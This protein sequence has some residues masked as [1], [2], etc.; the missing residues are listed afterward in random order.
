MGYVNRF[1]GVVGT[2]LLVL[3]LAVAAPA[4]AIDLDQAKRDG[5]V[6][7]TMEGYLAAVSDAPSAEVVALVEDINARRRAEYRRI[8]EQNG[9]ELSQVEALAAKKAIEK[10]R[11][12]GWV[13][14][15]GDWRRK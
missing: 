15:N 8:A 9:I 7:E 2:L 5:L 10:T 3:G 1:S 6:G 14:I 4:L 12:G 11:E 13:R